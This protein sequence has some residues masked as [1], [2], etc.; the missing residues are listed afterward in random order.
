MNYH[1]NNDTH[2]PSSLLIQY[3]KMGFKL[4][5]IGYDGVTPN[6]GGLLTPEEREFSIHESKSGKEEPLNYICYHP[7]FWNEE[8]IE[9][10]IDS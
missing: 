2:Q 6:V 4:V 3:H 1:N 10:E 7:E 9:R 5:P 8:R